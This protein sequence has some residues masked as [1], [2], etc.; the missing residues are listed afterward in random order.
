MLIKDASPN[1]NKGYK[2]QE[3]I[4]LKVP[5]NFRNILLIFDIILSLKGNTIPEEKNLTVQ[6]RKKR[7][8]FLLGNIELDDSQ[9]TDYLLFS[10]NFNHMLKRMY[11][12]SIYIINHNKYM[13]SV[14]FFNIQ[15]R[16]RI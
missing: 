12:K 8:M 2:Y 10:K 5:F 6:K 7:S 15:F 13:K 1:P 16:S 11:T 14:T 3:N 4:F 9:P